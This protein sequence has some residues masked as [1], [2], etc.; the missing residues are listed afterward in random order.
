L[1]WEVYDLDT[2]IEFARKKFQGEFNEKLFLEQLVYF[3]DLTM[4]E[5]VFLKESYTEKE[6]K[7]FLEKQVEEYIRKRIP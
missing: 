7:Y 2:I 5:T 3:G 6:I 1:K 4:A